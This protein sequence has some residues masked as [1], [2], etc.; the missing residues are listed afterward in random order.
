MCDTMHERKPII[1]LQ[2]IQDD[3][4]SSL[5]KM[6]QPIILDLRDNPCKF[7]HLFLKQKTDI[8]TNPVFETDLYRGNCLLID[9]IH[10]STIIIGN[11]GLDWLIFI[12]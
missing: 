6:N 5:G 11:S 9:I 3:K 8:L 10:Q 7:V 1:V 12:P 2:I 4:L